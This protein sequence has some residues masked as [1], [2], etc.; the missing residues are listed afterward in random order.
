[1]LN[2]NKYL[3]IKVSKILIGLGSVFGLDSYDR[4]L[5]FLVK[6]GLIAT[7]KSNN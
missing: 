1:M 3:R 7:V 4:V 2:R 5:S 6:R